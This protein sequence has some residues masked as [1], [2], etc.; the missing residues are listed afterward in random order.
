MKITLESAAL[1]E[2]E[3][4]I[5]GDVASEE[6]I[7]LLLLLKKRNSNKI[8][9]FKEEEQYIVD[10]SE[11]VFLE[12]CDNKTYAYL[13][14]DVYETK[15]K[16]YELKEL[17]DNRF[18]VQ[19]NKSVIVNNLHN[20][21]IYLPLCLLLYHKLLFFSIIQCEYNV[22]KNLILSTLTHKLNKLK[23]ASIKT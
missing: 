14:Q 19:I 10:M 7:S 15:Y 6:V 13:M 22:K 11:I 17:L 9:L 3:V 12:V 23:A 20:P 4:I 5:R 1:P 18:F 8:V 16:L 21:F 2:A